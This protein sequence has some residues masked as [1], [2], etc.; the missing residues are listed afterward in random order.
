MISPSATRVY[1][2]EIRTRD[3]WR[4]IGHGHWEGLSRKDVEGR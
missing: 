1:A 3:G 4:E 2:L